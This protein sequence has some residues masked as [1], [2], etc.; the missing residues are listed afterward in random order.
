LEWNILIISNAVLQTQGTTRIRRYEFSLVIVDFA[1]ARIKAREKQLAR[2]NRLS[3][4]FWYR[5]ASSQPTREVAPHTSQDEANEVPS[6]PSEVSVECSCVGVVVRFTRLWWLHEGNGSEG[7]WEGKAGKEDR[8]PKDFPRGPTR[9]EYSPSHNWT[10]KLSAFQPKWNYGSAALSSSEVNAG[11]VAE[12]SSAR[13]MLLYTSDGGTSN[14]WWA[15]WRTYCTWKILVT[16]A[17]S[18]DAIYMASRP[19]RTWGYTNARY[20]DIA[21][22]VEREL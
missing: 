18:Q 1:I 6:A 11:Y 20:R 22:N 17:V 14:R 12:A 5:V 8:Y 2:Y 16:T 13:P 21:R 3:F 10:E 19:F 9:C 7:T 4:I 15:T